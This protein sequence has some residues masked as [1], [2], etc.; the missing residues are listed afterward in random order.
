MDENQRFRSLTEKTI[1]KD[2]QA[3]VELSHFPCG[4][5]AGCYDLGI[6]ITE[7]A[8][9]IGEADFIAMVKELTQIQKRRIRG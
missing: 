8:Y 9:R 1:K 6:V 5:G 4:G 2:W 3:L 7:I